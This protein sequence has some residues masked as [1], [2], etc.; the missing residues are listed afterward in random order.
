MRLAGRLLL[1]AVGLALLGIATLGGTSAYYGGSDGRG[2]ARC[3]EIGASVDAWGGSTHRNVACYDCHGSSFSADVRMHVK[4]ASRVW[5]HSRGEVP[6]QIRLRHADVPALVERCGRCHARELADWRSGPHGATYAE[7]F[8]DEDHNRERALMDDC[9]RCHGMHF[10]GGIADLV[11]PIDRQGPWHLRDAALGEAPAIPCLTCHT[12]H[13]AGTPLSPL[14][15]RQAVPGPEQPLFPGSLA[16]YD[17]RSLD[18]IPAGRLPLPSV[19]DGERDVP[20]SPDP[21]QALCYQCHAPLASGQV[22]SGDDRTPTGVHEG[23]SCNACHAGHGQRTR[24]SC[25]GCHPRLSNCGLDVETMDTSFRT[26]ESPHDVHAVACRD[27]HPKGVPA[28]RASS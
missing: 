26:Q 17:R 9:L 21:R 7:L 19:V 20:I 6:G 3:H 24:A 8:L 16:L 15:G 27:C 14:P 25:A 11:T 28:P 22:F 4:N 12:V 2:C 23:L 1:I 13:R 10:E 5:L 18:H